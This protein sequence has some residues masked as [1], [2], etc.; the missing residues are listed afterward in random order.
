MEWVKF[1][2]AGT[3]FK[4]LVKRIIELF[5]AGV[6][7]SGET[8]EWGGMRLTGLLEMTG[9]GSGIEAGCFGLW[10]WLIHE[11]LYK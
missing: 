7:V 5:L 4:S 10:R 6:L 2:R 1:K 9:I 11:K 3:G 8:C